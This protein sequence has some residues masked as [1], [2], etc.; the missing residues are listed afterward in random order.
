M[1]HKALYLRNCFDNEARTSDAARDIF[2][3][4]LIW[5]A[6]GRFSVGLGQEEEDL[7]ALRDIMYIGQRRIGDVCFGLCRKR[8]SALEQTIGE[9]ASSQTRSLQQVLESMGMLVTPRHSK[10]SNTSAASTMQCED[11]FPPWSSQHIVWLG[12]MV[13]CESLE[14]KD[15]H[16][17]NI[18]HHLFH[19]A[20][21]SKLV[22]NIIENMASS[23]FP[24]LPGDMRR[25]VLQQTTGAHPHGWTPVHFLCTGSDGEYRKCA[26]IEGL[27][28]AMHL[29]ID[30]FNIPDPKVFVF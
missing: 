22:R 24:M 27:L 6:S 17:W 21:Q 28:N 10:Q 11:M 7:K 8:I 30:D 15:A 4:Q 25:A 13:S 19:C 29:L 23:Q 26:L 3:D 12:L 1:Q 16:G 14:D 2:V 5:L 18:L 20:V 9:R